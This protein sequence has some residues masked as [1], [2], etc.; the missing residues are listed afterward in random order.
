MIKAKVKGQWK[1]KFQI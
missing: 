1:D